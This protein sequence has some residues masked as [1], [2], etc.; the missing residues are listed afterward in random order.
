MVELDELA[1]IR[2]FADFPPETLQWI[3]NK[4]IEFTAEAGD[5]LLD[6]GEISTGLLLL[7]Q[8]EVTTSSL[9]EGEISRECYVAP[10][11]FGTL[12]VIA[13]IP[14]PAT[15]R[16]ATSCR[17][18]R[19][20]G[21]AFRELFV[22][23]DSFSRRITRR[24][25]GWLAGFESAGR[26]R[27]KLA[28]L[29]KLSAG[30]AH[31]LNNP[32]SAV[33]RALDYVLGGLAGLEESALALGW[34]AVP[35]EAVG[36]LRAIAA[37]EAPDARAAT[38]DPMGQSK[39]ESQLC[40]WLAEHRVAKPWLAATCLV[41]H[42]ITS[43]E[44]RPLAATLNEAQ[45]S[46]A[47]SWIAQFIEL[48]TVVLEAMRGAAR[49][50]EVVNTMKSYSYMDQGP[51]QEIDIHNGI[52]DTLTMMAHEFKG[53]VV[54]TR[55]YDRSLPRLQAYGSELNQVWTRIVENAVEAMGGCGKLTIRT[56]RNLNCAVV[57]IIDSG[58]GIPEEAMPH[59]FEPFYSLKTVDQM[60]ARGLGLH[61]AYRIVVYRHAGSIK[62]VSHPGETIFRVML[63]LLKPKST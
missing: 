6:E 49:I 3:Q 22:S 19:L 39:A 62:A 37:R 46:A 35:R 31:E 2:Q 25:S 59:L 57:E 45:F 12:G 21:P 15:A 58:P 8:G 1:R 18:A 4:V 17:L 7:L 51:Q 5:V 16:A 10:W 32:A 47:V 14:N 42:G 33:T 55:D 26:G 53:G 54:V 63:P 29:G 9:A 28:A 11:L 20:P 61:I 50:S 36:E 13:S 23:C 40:D 30:I 60:Q 27:E 41:A 24:M 34:N 38:E 52:E 44:L 48:R 43:D 56:R